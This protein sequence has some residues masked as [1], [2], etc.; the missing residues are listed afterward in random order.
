M[1]NI[2]SG[3]WTLANLIMDI[4]RWVKKQ[5]WRKLTVSFAKWVFEYRIWIALWVFLTGYIIWMLPG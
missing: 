1:W 4:G 2:I 3:A 5:E